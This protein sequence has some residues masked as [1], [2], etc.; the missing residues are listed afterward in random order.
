MKFGDNGGARAVCRA[1]L[2]AALAKM[3]EPRA[4]RETV[5][6]RLADWRRYLGV[7]ERTAKARQFSVTYKAFR[8]GP[9][10]SRI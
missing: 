8:R 2:A 10:A 5:Q 6:R 3:P 9:A 1:K 4:Q 7:L